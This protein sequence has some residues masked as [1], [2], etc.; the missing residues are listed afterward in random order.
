MLTSD[1]LSLFSFPHSSLFSLSLFLLLSLWQKFLSFSPSKA[2]SRANKCSYFLSRRGHLNSLARTEVFTLSRE[3]RGEWDSERERERKGKEAPRSNVP[4]II[5]F[6]PLTETAR[7]FREREKEKGSVLE[8]PSWHFFRAAT[9]TLGR[10]S[11]FLCV[12]DWPSLNVSLSPSLALTVVLSLPLSTILFF[13]IT[14][15]RVNL[16]S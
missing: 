6:L 2:F 13:P 12:L 1:S 4:L 5:L 9:N 7:N 10:W 8:L 15:Q 14:K 11:L 16:D 3:I